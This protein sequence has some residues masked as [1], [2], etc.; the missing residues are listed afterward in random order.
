VLARVPTATGRL[1]VSTG[2]VHARLSVDGVVRMET[3]ARV[4]DVAVGRH[5]IV[6]ES[7]GFVRWEGE[8]DVSA[9]RA[10]HLA[11]TMVEAP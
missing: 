9:G 8:L 1:L 6:L 4:D 5:A 2:E 11:V 3:P 7:D 10:T